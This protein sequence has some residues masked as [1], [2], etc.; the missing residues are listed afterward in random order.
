MNRLLIVQTAFLGDVVLSQPL[1][2]AAK[3]CWPNADIDVLVQPQWAPLLAADPALHEVLVFDKRRVDRGLTGLWRLASRLRR[4]R[5]DAAICPHPSFR[6]ALLLALAGIP[7]RVGFRDSAGRLFHTHRL[8]RDTSHPEPDRVLSLLAAWGKNIAAFAVAPRLALHPQ[9]IAQADEWRD[10]WGLPADRPYVC[11][12]PGSVWATKRWLPEGFATV[13][14]DLADDGYVPVILGGADDIVLSN[15]V[16]DRLRTLPVNLAGRLSLPELS[17]VLARAALLVTN[18]S[19]PMHIAGA[20]GTPVAA[21]FGSTT[22]SLGY[23]P[24][25][26]PNRVLEIEMPCRPCGPHGFQQCPLGHFHCM[27]R[28]APAEVTAACR[29]LLAATRL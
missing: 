1:W 29:E 8:P 3:Q 18:D 5:Y 16:Q 6:S 28:I 22:P 15:L 7:V 19:G 11:V 12:H 24:V 2:A 25:G 17:L 14:S 20:L 23:A 9:A 4:R 21:I 10:E 26:S 13:L 27:K